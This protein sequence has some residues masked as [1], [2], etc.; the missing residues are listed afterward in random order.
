[1]CIEQIAHDGLE[2]G[3]T[4]CG[5]VTREPAPTATPLQAVAACRRAGAGHRLDFARAPTVVLADLLPCAAV[6]FAGR[7]HRLDDALGPGSILATLT[8]LAARVGART[9][10]NRHPARLPIA[11]LTRLNALSA[12]IAARALL[13]FAEARI[14]RLQIAARPTRPEQHSQRGQQQPSRSKE[15]IN[16]YEPVVSIRNGIT[17][18][19]ARCCAAT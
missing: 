5:S 9:L 13:P 14:G 6:V 16:E 17:P 18:V 11:T 10:L 19:P 4:G 1:M 8:P 2:L 7:H 12:H 15:S 3:R